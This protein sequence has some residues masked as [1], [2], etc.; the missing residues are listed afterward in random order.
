[1]QAL[2]AITVK[3]RTWVVQLAS[4]KD[5]HVLQKRDGKWH[6]APT[7][8]YLRPVRGDGSRCDEI[9]DVT[10][11]EPPGAVAS[12][13]AAAKL[14]ICLEQMFDAGMLSSS[15]DAPSFSSSSTTQQ[16]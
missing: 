2:G 16:S 5:S 8:L 12:R 11:V 4:E 6:A 13:E 15:V 1:M 3:K 9:D 14:E 7:G 10:K